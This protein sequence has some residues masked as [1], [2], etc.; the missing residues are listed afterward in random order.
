MLAVDDDAKD[1]EDEPLETTEAPLM[2]SLN[3]PDEGD[4]FDGGA[5]APPL[6]RKATALAACA[7]LAISA[8]AI[9]LAVMLP[10]EQRKYTK[11]HCPT[12]DDLAPIVAQVKTLVSTVGVDYACAQTA[13]ACVRHTCELPALV[14]ESLEERAEDIVSDGSGG[15]APKVAAAAAG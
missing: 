10:L 7:E 4:A 8:T 2:G 11:T 6:R 1:G 9:A 14:F 3:A 13:G 15:D 5:P 12:A